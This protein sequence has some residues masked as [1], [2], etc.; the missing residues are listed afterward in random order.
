M[1]DLIAKLVMTVAAAFCGWFFSKLQTKR[2]QKQTDLQIISGAIKPLL[3]SISE[4]TDRLKLV[5]TELMDER[6]RNLRL[7]TERTELLGKIDNL[8]KEVQKLRKE[9]AK[10]TKTDE[11]DNPRNSGN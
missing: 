9:I 2:E 11:K 3:V 8:E 7:V 1:E 10:L 5:T 4:L 6:E